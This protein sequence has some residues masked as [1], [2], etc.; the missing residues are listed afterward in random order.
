[1]SVSKFT[2]F[3]AA[4]A[5]ALSAGAPAFAQSVAP[6]QVTGRAATTVT[7]PVR[8]L[9]DRQVRQV[10][11]VASNHVCRNAVANYELDTFDQDWCA[12]RTMD[13]TLGQF[14]A[15]KRSGASQL[16]L[17]QITVTAD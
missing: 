14:R 15:L 11:R 3:A 1:M 6:V 12:S 4:A 8:G 9:T 5:L 2:V 16:A 13:R 17:T 7:V 10:V